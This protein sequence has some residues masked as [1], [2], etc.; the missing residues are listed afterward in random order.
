M[1]VILYI[2][3]LLPPYLTQGFQEKTCIKLCSLRSY[4]ITKI[5]TDL[6]FLDSDELQKTTLVIYSLANLGDTLESILD[7]LDKLNR[8]GVTLISFF[9]YFDFSKFGTD[10]SSNIFLTTAIAMILKNNEIW[11]EIM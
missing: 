10:P 9:D 7:N 6:N 11:K 8:N 2:S 3:D 1:E 4:S 5:V